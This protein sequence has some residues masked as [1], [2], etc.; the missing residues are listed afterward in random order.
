MANELPRPTLAAEACTEFL[1]DSAP[2]TGRPPVAFLLAPFFDRW[3]RLSVLATLVTLLALL[4]LA[5]DPPEPPTAA[6]EHLP[7]DGFPPELLA[8]LVEGETPNSAAQAPQHVL[9]AEAATPDATDRGAP[10]ITSLGGGPTG[11]GQP[12][13]AGPAGGVR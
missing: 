2:P 9:K 8:A 1:A 11:A 7:S 12:A 4:G 13:A 6:L 10:V 5:G 3:P